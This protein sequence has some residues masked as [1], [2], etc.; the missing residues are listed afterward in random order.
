[1]EKTIL[2]EKEKNERILAKPRRSSVMS[3]DS[4]LHSKD[5][6]TKEDDYFGKSARR[7]YFQ[8]LKSYLKSDLDHEIRPT[9]KEEQRKYKYQRQQNKIQTLAL[10]KSIKDGSNSNDDNNDGVK[11]RDEDE[12][13][14]RD[15]KVGKATSSKRVSF[16]PQVNAGAS[17]SSDST[18][19]KHSFS[20]KRN[21]SLTHTTRYKTIDDLHESNYHDYTS[22]AA[23]N[24]NET[25][26]LSTKNR[27]A[28]EYET[29]N[30]LDRVEF[31]SI[32]P[33]HTYMKRCSKKDI[34]PEP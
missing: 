16:L 18:L 13:E 23:T 32:D 33:R 19:E 1:M 4:S 5:L 14:H 8:D 2:L 15:E 9:R 28:I 10:E 17:D 22:K 21:R 24:C 31:R 29:T 7:K 12:H 25:V 27:S 3:F 30:S 20:D 34:L 6:P 26:R 11:S